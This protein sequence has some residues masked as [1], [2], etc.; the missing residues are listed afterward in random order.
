[1]VSSPWPISSSE[2]QQ[3]SPVLPNYPAF[4][5]RTVL[6]AGR[7]T[8]LQWCRVTG[9]QG[10][11]SLKPV[12]LVVDALHNRLEAHGPNLSVPFVGVCKNYQ[13]FSEIPMIFTLRKSADFSRLIAVFCCL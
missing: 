4:P 1:M 3:F 7:E 2:L 12:N 10:S 9:Q 8:T 11:Q 5:S 6:L 13:F